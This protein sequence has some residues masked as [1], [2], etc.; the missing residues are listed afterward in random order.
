MIS[1]PL[2][3]W[4]LPARAR[5]EFPG[6]RFLILSSGRHSVK[7]YCI[8]N[9]INQMEFPVSMEI[10]EL[11]S[12]YHVAR[13]RSVSRAGQFLEIGQPT[14][15][16]HLQKIEREFGV[17]L[18][19]RVRRPIQLTS[20]G[21][22][23]YEL[24]KPIVEGIAEGI[25]VLKMRMDYPEHRGSFV[26]GAYPDL[27][28]HH[29]P[30]I[31]KEFRAHYPSVRIRLLAR[32]YSTLMSMVSAGDLDIA[33]GTMPESEYPSLEFSRLFTSD[34]VLVTPLGHELLTLPEVTLYD[35]VRW[36]LVLLGP[37]SHSRR[38]LEQVLKREGL[39]YD[40]VLEMDI[41]E[42]AKRYVEIGMGVAV[43][44]DYVIQPGTANSWASGS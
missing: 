4:A 2:A 16:T 43:T 41:M 12:F 21:L 20:D 31:V 30:P 38:S 29:L 33:L 44:H 42:M 39:K 27:V 22:V 3:E 40:I 36:P 18:F 23:F 8:I 34:Y 10:R 28:L 14:V 17:V 15:T 35:L 6:A 24:V 5:E 9:S 19:D 37:A 1:R 13:L 25:E 7:R 32:S 26:I 11:I